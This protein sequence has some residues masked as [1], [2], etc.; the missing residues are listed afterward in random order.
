MKVYQ[1]H[2]CQGESSL[3]SKSLRPA[4]HFPSYLHYGY[5]DHQPDDCVY[6]PTCE[7]CGSYD[8]D[9][10][11]HNRIISLRRGMKPRNP[12]HVTKNCETCGSNV[13]TNIKST[14]HNDIEWFRKRESLQAKKANTFTSSALR[15]KIP[16]KRKSISLLNNGCSKHMTNAKDYLNKY[17]EYPGLKVIYE[18]SLLTSLK[19]MVMV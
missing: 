12:Q 9:T 4:I 5:N 18:D 11:G 19:V 8:H 7:L 10:H 2:T 15:S 6:Y 17:G 1:H 3:R 16:T 13:H 14:D